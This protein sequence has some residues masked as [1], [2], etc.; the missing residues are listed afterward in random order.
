MDHKQHFAS[1]PDFPLPPASLVILV[2][3]LYLHT[4]RCIEVTEQ[5]EH[6]HLVSRSARWKMALSFLSV[7]HREIQQ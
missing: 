6:F 1:V 2:E 5:S 4:R 3:K 7:D